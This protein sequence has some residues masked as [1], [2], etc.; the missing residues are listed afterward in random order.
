MM[1]AQRLSEQ[2]AVGDGATAPCFKPR[3]TMVN[4]TILGWN[5]LDGTSRH[6]WIRTG[7]AFTLVKSISRPCKYH[8][9]AHQSGEY[10]PSTRKRNC[11]APKEAPSLTLGR[12]WLAGYDVILLGQRVIL[13]VSYML[14]SWKMV[15]V[16]LRHFETPSVPTQSSCRVSLWFMSL[17]S[18]FTGFATC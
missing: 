4:C 2:T 15:S 13:F 3:S 1:E 16:P 5:A 17:V 7:R 11:R 10:K 9:I 6:S 8:L 14:R 18:R 12:T